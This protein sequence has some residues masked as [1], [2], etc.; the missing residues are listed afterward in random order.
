[1]SF[2]IEHDAKDETQSSVEDEFWITRDTEPTKALFSE[3]GPEAMRLIQRFFLDMDLDTRSHFWTLYEL[4]YGGRAAGAQ[5]SIDAWIRGTVHLKVHTGNRIFKLA[6]AV[7]PLEKRLDILCAILKFRFSLRRISHLNAIYITDENFKEALNEAV[8][9]IKDTP[10]R[11]TEA[12][13][14][15]SIPEELIA[16]AAW[17]APNNITVAS[18][19]VKERIYQAAL[20]K[21]DAALADL[22]LFVETISVH[23]EKRDISIDLGDAKLYISYTPSPTPTNLFWKVVTGMCLAFFI[24]ILLPL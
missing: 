18:T 5:R 1:M 19:V 6:P 16:Y 21:R 13:K 20:L 4:H 23:S 9:A 11:V 24:F 14:G 7:M 10:N 22:K 3:A 12:L 2:T 8:Q 17:L 15:A